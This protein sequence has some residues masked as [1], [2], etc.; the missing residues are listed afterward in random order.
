[1]LV[2]TLTPG[3]TPVPP[4]PLCIICGSQG[5]AD[6]I[7]NVWLFAPVG[8][9]LVILGVRPA[10]AML[11]A[12]ALSA[13]VEG[14]QATIVTGRDASLGDV[15]FNSIGGIIGVLIVRKASVWLVP[16]RR[17]GRLL[18]AG[19]ILSACAT[20]ALTGLLLQPAFLPTPWYGQW[21][22][23]FGNMEF[24]HGRVLDAHLG[25]HVVPSRRLND[26]G[27]ARRALLAGEPL[28]VRVESSPLTRGL[29]AIF[30]VYDDRARE[31]FLLG[32]NRTA[33]DLYVRRRADDARMVNPPLRFAGALAGISGGDTLTLQVK[34]AG[35][36]W[37]AG[38]TAGMNCLGYSA[39][40]GWELLQDTEF[41]LG[42]ASLV[43]ALWLFALLTPTGY[44]LRGRFSVLSDLVVLGTVCAVI[45]MTSGLVV[46]PPSEWLGAL[47]GLLAGRALI[48]VVRRRLTFPS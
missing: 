33:L 10:R 24:Y 9:G 44:W 2:A 26:D 22:A 5:V 39:G 28:T 46:S 48:A 7:C 42:H 29:S 21:T 4:S 35:V 3:G 43:S 18:A 17:N 23:Q 13:F 45:P 8:A 20:I 27:A 19:A 40:A 16:T 36:K 41:L 6:A 31:Q 47:G 37:C 32:A 38:Q 11:L 25:G 12:G 1:M 34:R 15:V 14:M 30:S